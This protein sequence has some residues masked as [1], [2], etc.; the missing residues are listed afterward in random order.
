MQTLHSLNIRREELRA[1]IRAIH[2]A[3]GRDIKTVIVKV[4]EPGNKV[5]RTRR[6]SALKGQRWKEQGI[7]QLLE[8][9]AS[10]I[11][12]AMPLEEYELVE[13]GRDRFNFVHRG[14]RAAELGL[15]LGALEAAAE[16]TSEQVPA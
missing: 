6:C 7:Q 8:F 13:L 16:E 2:T 3:R 10:E 14:S 1:K 9:I 12:R 4:F 5:V 11:E 15:E